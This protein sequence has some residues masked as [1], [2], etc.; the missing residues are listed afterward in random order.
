MSLGKFA[1][2]LFTRRGAL[3]DV[4][5]DETFEVVLSPESAR[6]LSRSEWLKISTTPQPPDDVFHG[7]WLGFGSDLFRRMED[8]LGGRTCEINLPDEAFRTEKI[9]GGLRDR[10]AFSNAVYEDGPADIRRMSWL[11]LWTRYSA[12]SDDRREGMVSFWVDEANLSS[13]VLPAA[14]EESLRALAVWSGGLGSSVANDP[15]GAEPPAARPPGEVLAAAQ[16]TAVAYAR[17]ALGD[18]LDLSKRRLERDMKRVCEYY[19]QLTA[20][21]RRRALRLEASGKF[22]AQE[23]EKLAGKS[24]AI[25]R[26]RKSKI[27]DLRAHY[28]IEIAVHPA[29]VIRVTARAPVFPL[30][31]KRRKESRRFPL[32]YNPFIRKLE[33]LP[34]EACRHG[35]APYW[36]C[37]ERLHILCDRC[38]AACALCGRRFC[39]ACHAAC[40]KGCREEMT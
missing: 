33:P 32:V 5:G 38:F 12:V 39:R 1:K 25:E 34:C 24:K 15:A 17:E 3:V 29:A 22:G 21:T 36:M 13:G 7:E 31:L 10:V 14:A 30:V 8:L 11:L 35:D 37:D 28:A 23:K 9:R 2:E 20:E 4:M 18:C 27:E 6:A 19:G 26:E 16:H 40:P